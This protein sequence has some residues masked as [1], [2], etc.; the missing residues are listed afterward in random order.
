MVCEMRGCGWGRA[1]G[2]KQ[3]AR[4]S[5]KLVFQIIIS[6]Y[7]ALCVVLSGRTRSVLL[8]IASV[9]GREGV[10]ATTT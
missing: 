9:R 8:D 1:V 4:A 7:C 5:A 2:W 3:H 6:R 10:G